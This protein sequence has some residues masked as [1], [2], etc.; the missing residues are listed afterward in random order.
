[1][2]RMWISL[3]PPVLSWAMSGSIV[4]RFVVGLLPLRHTKSLRS[5]GK[6][7]SAEDHA[8]ARRPPH[9]PLETSR[10]EFPLLS[11]TILSLPPAAPRLLK[12][13]PRSRSLP[14]LLPR[15]FAAR[16][17]LPRR[18]DLATAMAPATECKPCL[19]LELLV[20]PQVA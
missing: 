11:G 13:H 17:V 8:K 7:S 20:A 2:R 10:V 14:L 1:M 6:A 12:Q 16:L 4:T 15:T 19:L 5:K 18:V 9:H 3:V